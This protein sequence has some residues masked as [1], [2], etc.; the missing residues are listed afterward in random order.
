[1]SL[2]LLQQAIHSFLFLILLLSV[3]I[4]IIIIIIIATTS[5]TILLMITTNNETEQVKTH[6]K[7]L[8]AIKFAAA[9]HRL[10]SSWK[11]WVSV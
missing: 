3:L 9:L 5:G 1:V 8:S 7:E 11:Q 4:I 10:Q 6:C 2:Q